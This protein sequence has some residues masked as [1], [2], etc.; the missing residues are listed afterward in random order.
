MFVA[1]AYH[2]YKIL[3][4]DFSYRLRFSKGTIPS[5]KTLSF[6]SEVT[7]GITL[8]RWLCSRL[9]QV[10]GSPKEPSRESSRLL[11]VKV[12]S[13]FGLTARAAEKFFTLTGDLK[14]LGNLFFRKFTTAPPGSQSYAENYVASVKPSALRG[15]DVYF[16]IPRYLSLPAVGRRVLPLHFSL[17]LDLGRTYY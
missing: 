10:C 8:C 17:R 6:C 7:R 13:R 9:L 5:H 14:S 3:F 2:I 16:C 4:P 12:W 15:S 11:L 1:L